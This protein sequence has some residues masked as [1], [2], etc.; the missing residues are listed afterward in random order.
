MIFLKKKESSRELDELKRQ[1]DFEDNRDTFRD[2]FS[3]L[4]GTYFTGRF[5]GCP[6]SGK[7]PQKI[8]FGRIFT[9]GVTVLLSG[10]FV[11]LFF[12]AWTD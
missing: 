11:V 9:E 7:H 10:L 2:E 8:I 1:F 6:D 3:F 12:A 4:I 5:A